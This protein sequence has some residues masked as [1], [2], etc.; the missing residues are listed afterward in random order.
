[1]LWFRR[2]PTRCVVHV[3]GFASQPCKLPAIASCIELDP[4]ALERACQQCHKPVSLSVRG[5][6]ETFWPAL[7]KAFEYLHDQ[8]SQLVQA[9]D[10]FVQPQR[11][12]TLQLTEACKNGRSREE[13]QIDFKHFEQIMDDLGCC[14]SRAKPIL[15]IGQERSAFVPYGI[16]AWQCRQSARMQCRGARCLSR[17]KSVNNLLT[18]TSR[19][20][21]PHHEYDECVR[22][23]TNFVLST[24]ERNERHAIPLERP[25]S[26]R[27]SGDVRTNLLLDHA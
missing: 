1:M 27:C 23:G 20:L 17:G 26:S 6:A 4:R 14:C 7:S 21:L 11:L 12:V 25:V 3:V 8:H 24:F 13:C 9:L 16:V 10:S 2:F 5:Y 18:H 15:K 22:S 19:L